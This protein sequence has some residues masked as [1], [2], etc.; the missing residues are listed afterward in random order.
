MSQSKIATSIREELT[1]PASE[2][3]RHAQMSRIVIPLLEIGLEENVVFAQFR[4]MYDPESLPDSEIEAVLSWAKRKRGQQID[5]VRSSK[6]RVASLGEALTN[7]RAYLDGFEI[8]QA[9]LWDT[10]AIHPTEDWNQDSILLLE[11]LYRQEEL[12]SINTNYEIQKRSDEKQKVLIKAPEHTLTA[13]AWVDRIREQGTPKSEAGAWIRLNPVKNSQGS[14]SMGMHTDSDVAAYRYLLLESD[15]LPN[16]TWLGVLAKL[17]FPIAAIITTGGR[18]PH[19]WIKMPRENEAYFKAAAREIFNKL[20]PLGI[21]D[22]NKNP[23]RYGRLPGAPRILGAQSD[24]G[25]Q[26][27]FYLNPNP[28]PGGIYHEFFGR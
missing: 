12:V 16:D 2:G 17:P 6:R 23:S 27:L 22:S 24:E 20:A 11:R 25:R 10:S 1:T 28:H 8:D 18:A 9:C 13:C 15:F 14:G 3:G 5:E 19:G 21:D 26:Q 7:T 4:E